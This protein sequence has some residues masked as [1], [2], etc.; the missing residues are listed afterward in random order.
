MT[1]RDLGR[2]F[3]PEVLARFHREV[4]APS[5]AAE[6]LESL[7]AMEAGVRGGALALVAEAGGD[8][9][10]GAIAERHGEVLLVGYLAVHPEWRGRGIG[11]SLL[12][13]LREACGAGEDVRLALGEVHDP[14]R[15]PA[16]DGDRPLDRLRF[17][18]RAGARV[19]DVPFV[20]PGLGPGS[21]RVPGF[22]L[23]A[24]YSDAGIETERSVPAELVSGFVRSY[25]RAMER[26][27]A[28]Y[29]AELEG[30]LARIEREGTV[31]LLP[32][33]EYAR[34]R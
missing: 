15:H 31:D 32:V 29:E 34:V 18:E 10:G 7:D 26:A 23:L 3:D 24:L 20:Q 8:V 19:L 4:L 13:A 11:G 1:I 28:P 12:G 21:P 5:F 33:S 16:S 22:L 9:V 2:D 27:E 14:R 25:Y 17:F 30:L 6:E